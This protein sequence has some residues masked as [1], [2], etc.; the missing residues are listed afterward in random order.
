MCVAKKRSG[1]G[2]KI[3]S[4]KGGKGGGKIKEK[5][6]SR[7]GLKAPEAECRNGTA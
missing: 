7:L 3:S 2:V 4:G 5:K 1:A 6:C